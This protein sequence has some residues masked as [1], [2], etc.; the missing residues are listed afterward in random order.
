MPNAVV[1][2]AQRAVLEICRRVISTTRH[3]PGSAEGC[4]MDF[5]VAYFACLIVFALGESTMIDDEDTTEDL[6]VSLCSFVLSLFLLAL[7]HHRPAR[8]VRDRHGG[9]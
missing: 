9:R 1:E 4:T 7:A 6:K 5:I 3:Q 8:C 2:G